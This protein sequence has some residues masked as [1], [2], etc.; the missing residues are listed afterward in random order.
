MG[1]AAQKPSDVRLTYLAISGGRKP[2]RFIGLIG[3]LASPIPPVAWAP[4]TVGNCNH[5]DTILPNHVDNLVWEPLEKEPASTF[6]VDRPC[7]GRTFDF[8]ESTAD[9]QLECCGGDNA[10][11]AIPCNGFHGFS[12]RRF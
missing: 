11:V 2:V 12:G 6:N 5:K 4:L 10:A 7:F 8:G 3:L 1:G 9:L